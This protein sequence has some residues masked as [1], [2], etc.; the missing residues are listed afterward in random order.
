MWARVVVTPAPD[1]RKGVILEIPLLVTEGM[2][3]IGLPPSERDAPRIKSICPPTPEYCMLPMVSAQ[4]CPVRS[5][6]MAEFMAVT[7]GFLRITAVSL[8]KAVS[9]KSHRG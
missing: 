6:S 8:V 7:L 4:T 2:A 3:K 5:I 1:L 9:L